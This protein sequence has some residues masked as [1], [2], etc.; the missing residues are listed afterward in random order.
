MVFAITDPK[1]GQ[2]NDRLQ[3]TNLCLKLLQ[4]GLDLVVRALDEEVR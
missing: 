3:I 4:I 2:E 1:E